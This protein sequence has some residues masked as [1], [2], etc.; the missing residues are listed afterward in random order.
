MNQNSSDPIDILLGNEKI[1]IRVRKFN[2]SGKGL[3]D[4][5]SKLTP[6]ERGNLFSS[7]E[8]TTP[9]YPIYEKGSKGVQSV[10]KTVQPGQATS[11]LVVYKKGQSGIFGHIE[12][13]KYK[14]LNREVYFMKDYPI[15]ETLLTTDKKWIVDGLKNGTLL[16][17]GGVVRYAPG[18]PHAGAIAAFLKD[19][20]NV[21]T[22]SSGL[23]NQM[24]QTFL[25]SSV[26]SAASVLNL[27]LSTAG[28][29]YLAYQNHQL[30]KDL[31]NLDQKV[32]ENFNKIDSRF[33]DVTE[34]LE[35]LKWFARLNQDTLNE[36]R[37]EITNFRQEF[38]EKEQSRFLAALEIARDYPKLRVFEDNLR[39]FKELKHALYLFLEKNRLSTNNIR[40]IAE[41]GLKFRLWASSCAAEA[42]T[43]ISL[44]KMAKAIECFKTGANIS[45]LWAQN[46]SEQLFGVLGW[47]QLGHTCFKNNILEDRLY[48]IALVS[49]QKEFTQS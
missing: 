7:E 8:L 26:G 37:N 18:Q 20:L 9:G 47:S 4:L 39:I 35:E 11:G 12:I 16:R 25:M 31:V 27:G 36:I 1:W 10:E 13:E 6:Q 23:S 5:L 34:R 14:K 24:A 41:T 21:K 3:Y 30:K 43:F 32:T 49:E 46:W 48:R 42:E 17:E 40:Q 2:T 15:D 33:E 19:G 44:N 38:F 45:K 29:A 22:L 28:F